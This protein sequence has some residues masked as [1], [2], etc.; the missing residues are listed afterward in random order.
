MIKDIIATLEAQKKA[1]ATTKSFCD[2]MMKQA[3]TERDEEQAKIE[4]NN[5]QIA[6]KEAEK[7]QLEGEIAE[8]S[9]DIANLQKALLEATELR[10]DEKKDN[11]MVIGEAGVGKEAVEYALQLLRQFY[12]PLALQQLNYVP[13]NSD[14]EGN[15]VGDLAPEIFDEKY[16]GDQASSKGILGMLEVILSDFERTGDV[17]SGN[18]KMSAKQFAD[19]KKK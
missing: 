1:E 11:L 19:Y 7:A 16:K 15:T 4:D 5:A 10:A 12:E 17:V 14:R 2:K 6:Q 13:P 3:V 8:L 18:E 9:A